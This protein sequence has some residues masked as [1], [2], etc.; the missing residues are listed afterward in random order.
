MTRFRDKTT[1]E[2]ILLSVGIFFFLLY[3]LL[4]LLFVFYQ[5]MPFDMQPWQKIG[6][7]VVLIAYAVF[8]LVRLIRN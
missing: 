8:R 4:G 1:R 6:F 3:F 7:G 5:H 2:K